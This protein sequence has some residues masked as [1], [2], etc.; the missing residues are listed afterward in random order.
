MEDLKAA[1]SEAAG[2]VA[3]A[4]KGRAPT[5]TGRLAASVR[6]GASKTAALIRAG[7]SS[8]T[9]AP[10]VHWG[11]ARRH[12][13]PRPFISEAAQM[14]EPRWTPA[15]EEAIVAALDRVTGV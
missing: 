12:I 6:P 10:V 13:R 11:W 3:D 15:Y 9:Y 7:K 4:S 1:H 5:R 14:T 2:I 8:V